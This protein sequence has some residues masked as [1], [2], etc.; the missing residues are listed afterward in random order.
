MVTLK[1]P[2]HNSCIPWRNHTLYIPLQN[3]TFPVPIIKPSDYLSNAFIYWTITLT[4]NNIIAKNLFYIINIFIQPSLKIFSYN[5]FHS[6]LPPLHPLNRFLHR[7]T[8]RIPDIFDNIRI[9]FLFI[10]SFFK[11]NNWYSCVSSIMSSIFVVI[12]FHPHFGQINPLTLS[13]CITVISVWHFLH[14]ILMSSSPN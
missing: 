8:L 4:V 2:F 9:W 11:T 7:N 1:I 10:C 3:S 5:I 6:V 12:I 14:S 13:S